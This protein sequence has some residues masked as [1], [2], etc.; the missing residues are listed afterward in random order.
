MRRRAETLLCQPPERFATIIVYWRTSGMSS[1]LAMSHGAYVTFPH[2]AANRGVNSPAP[3]KGRSKRTSRRQ[4]TPSAL[5]LGRSCRRHPDFN[6]GGRT[7]A[8]KRD[9]PPGGAS[10]LCPTPA[11]AILNHRTRMREEKEIL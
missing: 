7:I 11:N 9:A 8:R 5:D 2:C 10:R 4:D 3:A 1:D 6:P